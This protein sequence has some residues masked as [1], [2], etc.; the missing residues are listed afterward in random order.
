MKE[1]LFL[2]LVTSCFWGYSQKADYGYL[3]QKSS[4]QKYLSKS[5]DIL[6]V[7]DT[8]MIGIPSS[9]LGFMYISQGGYGVNTDLSHKKVIIN[10]LRTY[11]KK[12]Q[13][14]KMYVHFKG[15]GLAPVVIDYET[16]LE[17]GEIINPNAKLS[18]REA[19]DKLKEAKELFD[20][21]LLTS[22]ELDSIKSEL[23]P[24]IMK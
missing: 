17:T 5:G 10:K 4:Y 9:D 15:Y 20:L 3:T 18:R 21:G 13:G 2:V 23:K 19:I 6:N 1:L 16:A 11:G 12:S 8:L 24:L 7:A 22:V 14:F